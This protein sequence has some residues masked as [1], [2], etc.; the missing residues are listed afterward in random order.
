MAESRV[1]T[2]PGY[3][4]DTYKLDDLFGLADTE[5]VVDVIGSGED[6]A[7]NLAQ[8][9]LRD[10][11]R[12]T[13]E[14][15]LSTLIRNLGGL[16][17][18]EEFQLPG[19]AGNY[20]PNKFPKTMGKGPR[21]PIEISPEGILVE[22]NAEP[23]T[24][25]HELEHAG[26]RRLTNPSD[27]DKVQAGGVY[28]YQLRDVPL[29]DLSLL[30]EARNTAKNNFYSDDLDHFLIESMQASQNLRRGNLSEKDRWGRDSFLVIGNYLNNP[31]QENREAAIER[32]QNVISTTPKTGTSYG[33]K[34]IYNTALSIATKRGAGLRELPLEQEILPYELLDSLEQAIMNFNMP[35]EKEYSQKTTYA[36][37]GAV[38]GSTVDLGQG[39]PYLS[40]ELIALEE[41]KMARFFPPQEEEPLYVSEQGEPEPYYQDN[42]YYGDGFRYTQ[43]EPKE[44]AA[45]IFERIEPRTKPLM[46]DVD[47][48][49]VMPKLFA[50]GYMGKRATGPSYEQEEDSGGGRYGLDVLT[51]S[52]NQ[53]GISR[54]AGYTRGTINHS[55]EVQ[56]YYGAPA[57]EKYGTD[58]IA[59]GNISGYYRSPNGYSVEGS[60]NPDTNN[61][62]IQAQ[63]TIRFN[64]GGIVAV[65]REQAPRAA[66]QRNE[67]F[68]AKLLKLAGLATTP[69]QLVNRVDPR[70]FEQIDVVLGR[71]PG[72]RS[73]KTPEGG[74]GS[75]KQY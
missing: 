74:I 67:A 1:N 11:Q 66:D 22:Q 8:R 21:G 65:T 46:I 15:G 53:F 49:K 37:G 23:S 35:P 44:A 64:E 39:A 9:G 25:R 30:I 32:I 16:A 29:D 61:Y 69:R 24:I 43:V 58:G 13:P 19:V 36:D 54:D 7:S 47:G 3:G 12:R 27:F 62:R 10:M 60:Y 17:T 28:P 42:N 41:A 52:G 48:Y 6:M 59:L 26:I 20:N 70:L 2:G 18:R 4:N 51:P 68:G 14:G 38:E 40:E 55:E 71:R 56:R 5:F 34:V 57:R 63:R 75:M 73:F 72:E 50:Q 31:T 33:D 45:P